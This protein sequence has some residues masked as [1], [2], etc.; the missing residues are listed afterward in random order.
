MSLAVLVAVGAWWYGD[1]FPAVAGRVAAKAAGTV[2]KAAEDAGARLSAVDSAREAAE[3]R[4]QWVPLGTATARG[5]GVLARLGRRSGPAYVSVGADS[6]G[7]ALGPSLAAMLP[8]RLVTSRALALQG[9]RLFLRGVVERGEL[10]GAGA[11]VSLLGGVVEGRDTLVLDGGLSL[12][13]P[14]VLAYTVRGIRVGRV[15]VPDPLHSAVLGRLRREAPDDAAD[16]SAAAP[17]AAHALPLRVPSAVADV[18]IVDG[19]V[20][21]YRTVPQ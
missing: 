12:V 4:R 6:L 18:R 3:A 21:F 8:E 11:L 9:E 13:R 14:G 7:A 15:A 17:I 16:T 19:R 1:R 10:L 5:G 2:A 20:V